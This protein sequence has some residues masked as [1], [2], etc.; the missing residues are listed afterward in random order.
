MKRKFIVGNWKMYTTSAEAALLA[1]AVVDGA[2]DCDGVTTV[3]CPPF[4]Y[5]ALVG[6]VLEGTAVALGAQN[7]YPEKEGAFTGEVSPSML[8]DLGCKYVILGHSERRLKL[9]ESDRFIN[10][11]VLAALATG[12]NVI[13]CIGETLDQR[14]ANQ[15][16]EVLKRQL[17]QGLAHVSPAD[18]NRLSIGY[19]PVWAIGGAGHVDTPE[20]AQETIGVVRRRFSE[21]FGDAPADALVISYGGSVNP[22]DAAAL[23]GGNGVD[24]ALIGHD[25][26][27]ADQFLAIIRAA[28]PGKQ[29]SHTTAEQKPR[30]AQLS[31]EQAGRQASPLRVYFVRHGETKWS[32]TGQHTGLIDIPLTAHGEEEARKLQPVLRDVVF[33][34]VLTSPSQRA[35]QTCQLAGLGQSAETQ[36]DSVEWNYGDYEGMRSGDV[37]EGRPGWDLFRDGCPGGETPQ[38]ISDRADRLIETLRTLRGN[39][40]LFSHGQF[41]CVVAARWIGL[42]VLDGQHFAMG[43][44]SLSILS[45][46]PHH[47][48]VPVISLWNFAPPGPIDYA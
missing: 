35:R 47:P 4:P 14:Q 21:M 40:A 15:T 30:D 2:G 45:F 33:D 9:N 19:E 10:Q 37:Q 16:D 12:L 17:N 25:S 43:P 38:Q 39:V 6:Q 34:K 24:G 1:K 46:D 13:F 5:L 27:N 22:N 42:P 48:D 3:L 44:A 18:L 26:L 28:V 11:K 36:A 29:S 32:L 23:L 31:S 20:Q 8:V 7:L 41:G